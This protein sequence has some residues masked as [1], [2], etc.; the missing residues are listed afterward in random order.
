MHF[1]RSNRDPKIPP[2]VEAEAEA[3][4]AIAS[5][6]TWAVKRTVSLT[7]QTPREVALM[8]LSLQGPLEEAKDEHEEAVRLGNHTE[9]ARRAADVHY[10]TALASSWRED[11]EADR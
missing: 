9:V 6:D 1:G 4:M 10:W 3:A 8:V 7:G 2:A 11:M 5:T